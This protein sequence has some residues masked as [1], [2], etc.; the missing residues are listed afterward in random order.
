MARRAGRPVGSHRLQVPTLSSV[1][2]WDDDDFLAEMFVQVHG[3]AA[4]LLAMGPAPGLLDLDP[5]ACVVR[6]LGMPVNAKTMDD[7]ACH[8]R[9]FNRQVPDDALARLQQVRDVQAEGDELPKDKPAFFCEKWCEF[10]TACRGGEQPKELEEI[11]DPEL[12]AAVN[13]FGLAGEL[14]SANK[15]IQAELRDLLDGARGR[16]AEGYKIWHGRGNPAK[17]EFD[18]AAVEAVLGSRGI[19]LAEVMAWT[20]EGRRKMY[21]KRT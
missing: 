20:P 10:Y 18:G 16:T 12:K 5:D 14:I 7:W 1:R 8:E 4:G 2:L 15:K 3:Y 9:P 13:A 19:P 6:L 11:T 21:V 17:L